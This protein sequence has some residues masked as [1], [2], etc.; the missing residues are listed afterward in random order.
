[1]AKEFEATVAELTEIVPPDEMAKASNV[2]NMLD[3]GANEIVTET[4]DTMV[5]H[6]EENNKQAENISDSRVEDA[7]DKAVEEIIT[8]ASNNNIS[9][10]PPAA[11]APAPIRK[12]R[13]TRKYTHRQ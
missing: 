12:R 11:A 3:R 8:T 4:L 10:L 7:A 5:Q 13:Y 9:A 1:M 2:N 6:L